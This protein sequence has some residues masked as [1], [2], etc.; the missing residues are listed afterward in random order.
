MGMDLPGRWY[1]VLLTVAF[2]VRNVASFSK[3]LISTWSNF[4]I[5]D[6]IGKMSPL[7]TS[8]NGN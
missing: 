4:D 1:H 8:K 2:D 7:E 3:L 6:K 5:I